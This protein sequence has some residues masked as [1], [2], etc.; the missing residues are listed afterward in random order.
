[1]T[2]PDE[3]EFHGPVEGDPRGRRRAAA[4][5]AGILAGAAVLL[6]VGV[7]AAMGASP[8]TATG[9]DPSAS[10]APAASAAPGTNGKVDRHGHNGF[11][12]PFG[13]GDFG[14]GFRDI[15]ITAIDGSNVSLETEDGWTRTI[16]VTDSTTITKAGATIG[17]GD[18][19]VGDHVRFAQQRGSDGTWTVTAIVVVLPTVVGEVTAVTGSTITVTQRGRTTATIHV[20]SG[21]IYRV[22]GVTGSLS[23]I[24]VG[25]IVVAEGTQRSDGSLDAATVR[26]GDRPIDGRGP[27]WMH[28]R[29]AEPG[30]PASPAPSSG[31]S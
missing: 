27:G 19:A 26:G 12:G 9:A 11:A 18:L 30:A 17:I 20:G 28:D 1:M 15:T 8:S 7:V 24:K 21:T 31:T 14:H 13:F 10:P 3:I 5:R 25:S 16:T 22:N 4:T 2:E 6:V 23:D 29:G